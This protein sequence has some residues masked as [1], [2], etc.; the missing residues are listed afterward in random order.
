PRGR[1]AHAEAG[2][3]PEDPGRGRGDPCRG[4]RRRTRARRGD[5]FPEAGRDGAAAHRR[6]HGVHGVGRRDD[7][8]HPWGRLGRDT[9]AEP[10][11]LVAFDAGVV[12]DGYVG[13]LGR[14]VGVGEND[15]AGRDLRR[16]RD[17]QWERLLA[18]CRPGAAMTDLIDAYDAQGVPPPVP[19]ARGLGLGF[20]LPLVTHALPGLAAAQR[21]EAGMVLALT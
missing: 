18:A 6:F 11:H 21:F 14:T 5:R 16:H 10:G 1:R 7:P 20:Y 13:E 17:A 2:P 19:V 12:L 8:G 9:P 15:T 4:R 3:H